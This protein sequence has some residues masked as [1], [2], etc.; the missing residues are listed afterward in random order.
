M[1]A[2]IY[3]VFFRYL[4][5]WAWLIMDYVTEKIDGHWHCT[6]IT[7]MYFMGEMR[8]N[9]KLTLCCVPRPIYSIY[10]FICIKTVGGW[11]GKQAECTICRVLYVTILAPIAFGIGLVCLS[12]VLLLVIAFLPGRITFLKVIRKLSKATTRL[13]LYC[14]VVLS[15]SNK[16]TRFY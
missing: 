1:L 8:E 7:N 16:K 4:H 11:R 2:L 9:Y 5:I 13:H 15:G 3:E 10:N 6:L 14:N 12:A